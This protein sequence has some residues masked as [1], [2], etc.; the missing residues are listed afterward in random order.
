MMAQSFQEWVKIREM[1]NDATRSY[2]LNVP[3]SSDYNFSVDQSP[4][5]D[6]NLP[7]QMN[8]FRQWYNFNRGSWADVEQAARKNPQLMKFLK[9]AAHQLKN[10]PSAAI[11]P[12]NDAEF[13]IDN[14]TP[15][16]SIADQLEKLVQQVFPNHAKNRGWDIP[17]S[18]YK[19]YTQ[20]NT[21]TQ[22]V[23]GQERPPTGP[24]PNDGTTEVMGVIKHLWNRQDDLE[25]KVDNLSQRIMSVA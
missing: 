3:K 24:N 15:M 11:D 23:T 4:A 5:R 10:T 19:P 25:K 16:S 2:D 8:Q 13:N 21:R 7:W 18:Y 20:G 22:P 1:D 14:P 6:E 12:Y 9:Q 17:S